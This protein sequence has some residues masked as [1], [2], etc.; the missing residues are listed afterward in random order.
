M[1][2]RIR[3][4]Q[5]EPL[6]HRRCKNASVSESRPDPIIKRKRGRDASQASDYTVSTDIS[7]NVPVTEVE[8]RAL[9]ILLGNDLKEL[10]AGKPANP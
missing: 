9:D 10:L 1:S 6:R 2:S 7:E 5:R 8:L 3:Q 4:A